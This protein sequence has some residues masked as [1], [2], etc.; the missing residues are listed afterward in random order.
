[1]TTDPIEYGTLNLSQLQAAADLGV[2]SLEKFFECVIQ[3]KGPP[4]DL[5]RWI[6]K[7][8][9]PEGSV[10]AISA[11]RVDSGFLQWVA[12]NLKQGGI[13]ID[14]TQFADEDAWR[15]EVESWSA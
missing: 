14:Y 6:H 5:Y 11:F 1:M 2:V 8:D 4:E 10:G 15:A 9:T 7:H 13:D 12:H 3:T